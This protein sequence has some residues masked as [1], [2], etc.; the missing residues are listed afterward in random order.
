MQQGPTRPQVR[1]RFERHVAVPVEECLRRIRDALEAP[2][3]ELIGKVAMRHASIEVPP[4]TKHFWSP[5]MEVDLEGQEDETTV[6]YVRIGPSPPVFTGYIALQA[7]IFFCG[8]GTL[9]YAWSQHAAGESPWALWL[10]PVFVVLGAL[11]FGG[12]FVGQGLGAEEMYTLRTFLDRILPDSGGG[13]SAVPAAM[14][15]RLA[16]EEDGPQG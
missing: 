9:I 14:R 5:Q 8:L 10:F 4:E 3:E 12:A 6:L 15:R 2:E 11:V 16:L 13:Q 7:V 1:P